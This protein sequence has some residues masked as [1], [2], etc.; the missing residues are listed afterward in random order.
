MA[1]K[2]S[3]A[4]LL[5]FKRIFSERK[6]Q[7]LRNIEEKSTTELDI[8]IDGDEVDIVQGMQISDLISKLSIR[9]LAQIKKLNIAIDKIER[10]IFGACINCDGAIGEKRLLALPGIDICVECAEEEERAKKQYA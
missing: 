1:R 6:D 3:A 5:K 7:L 10:G 8:D 2:F 9:D 4:K